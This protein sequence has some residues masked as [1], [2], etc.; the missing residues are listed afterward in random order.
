[1][2]LRQLRT[3]EAVVAHRT[4]TDAANALGLA[5]SSVSEQIR[6]LEKSLGVA[7]FDRGPK[8]MELTAAGERMRGWAR[9]LLRQAEQARAEVAG[10]GPVLRLGALESIAATHV[11]GV[12]ARLAERRPGLRVDVRS[13]AARDQLLAAVAAGELEA[14]LLLDAGGDVGG[15]GFAPPPAPL[16]FADLEP[17]PLALV[18]APDHPLAGAAHVAAADLRDEK[19]LVNVPACSFHMAGERLFGPAVERVRAGSVTVMAS[20]AERGLGIALVPE[21]AVRDRL[22]A[23][24]LVRLALGTPALSLRL[25]WR[26]DR[27]A[28]PGMREVL[29]AASA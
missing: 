13:D 27:E 4:V 19:F 12:L 9:R 29:Y 17:V 23:G 11:P 1:M 28:L 5:P 8:G 25:V 16:D 3:F 18:A 15:L 7:L 6:T 2:E 20:W 26:A 22:A 21:F 24:T 14:A 10:E